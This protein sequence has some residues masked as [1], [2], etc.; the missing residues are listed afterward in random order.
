LLRHI[1]HFPRRP[2]AP[3]ENPHRIASNPNAKT[4]FVG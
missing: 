4:A 1:A 3:S 2:C